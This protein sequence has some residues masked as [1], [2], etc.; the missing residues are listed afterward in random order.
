M[1][2]CLFIDRAKA[3][4]MHGSLDVFLKRIITDCWDIRYGRDRKTVKTL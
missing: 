2:A 1:S 3:R 4:E